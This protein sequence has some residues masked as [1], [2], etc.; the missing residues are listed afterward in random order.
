MLATAIDVSTLPR[1]C[2]DDRWWFQQKL[3]GHR[4]LIR[5]DNG[6]VTAINRRG[7]PFGT[8]AADHVVR[9]L[10]SSGGT[11]AFDGE[12]LG[13]VLWAFDF[14]A[15]PHIDVSTPYQRRLAVLEEIVRCSGMTDVIRVLPT[16]RTTE[17]KAALAKRLLEAHCEGVMVKDC[18]ARYASGRRTRLVRKAKFWNSADVVVMEINRKGKDALEVGVFDNGRL[19]PVGA[20]STINDAATARVTDVL[21]VRYLYTSPGEHRLVQPNVLRRRDDKLAEECTFDQLVYPCKEV[22]T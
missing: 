16:A 7:E 6:R 11:M 17:E 8:S 14:I 20:V 15:P 22:L 21:E 5:V 12:L 4:V 9:A 10:R 18:T 13:G 19:R 2:E 1:Y 3:D